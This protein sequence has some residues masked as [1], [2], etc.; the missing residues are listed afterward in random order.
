MNDSSLPQLLRQP[1][2]DEFITNTDANA[3]IGNAQPLPEWLRRTSDRYA[4]SAVFHRDAGHQ[5]R[6]FEPLF[7]PHRPGER[8]AFCHGFQGQIY[9]RGATPC[10]SIPPVSGTTPS[11]YNPYNLGF[12]YGY[13]TDFDTRQNLTGD[14]IWNSPKFFSKPVNWLLGGWITK[15]YT[16]TADDLVLSSAAAAFPACFAPDFRGQRSGQIARLTPQFSGFTAPT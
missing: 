1:R 3:Y 11:V 6:L 14:I 8:H 2:M 15:S 5:F 10:N 4:R 9:Y 13:S 7:R 16:S 12:G